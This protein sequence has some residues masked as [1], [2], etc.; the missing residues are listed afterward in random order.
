MDTVSV[1]LGA[2][3]LDTITVH[4]DELK[5]GVTQNMI[6]VFSATVYSRI[7]GR[8]YQH[9]ELTQMKTKGFCH[10]I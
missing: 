3:C 9:V 6:I 4:R 5:I 1:L 7:D 10:I 8:V 2:S